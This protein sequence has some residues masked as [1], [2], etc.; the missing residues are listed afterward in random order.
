MGKNSQ[1]DSISC[2]LFVLFDK[3]PTDWSSADLELRF[4]EWLE[5]SAESVPM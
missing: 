5:F 2:R 3:D 4:Q 1:D